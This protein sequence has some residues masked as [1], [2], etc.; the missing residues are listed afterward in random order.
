MF[1]LLHGECSSLDE[2]MVIDRRR[3]INDLMNSSFSLTRAHHDERASFK[4]LTSLRCAEFSLF[5][6]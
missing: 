5:S 1:T 6:K 2:D 3:S 4:L